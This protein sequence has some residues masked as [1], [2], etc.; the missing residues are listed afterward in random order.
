MKKLF[1]IA[2]CALFAMSS[3]AQN[4]TDEIQ[5]LQSSYGMDKK[6]LI[7]ETMKF[8]E[9][10]SAKFWP[11]YNNYEQERKKLGQ[12]RI[13]NIMNFARNNEGMTNEK[14][15]ELVNATLDNH[16]AFTKL[17]Q[18]TYKE[19]SGAITPLRAAQFIQLE[20]FL[21]NVIRKEI[22][23]AIPMIGKVDA[24]EKK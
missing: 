8:T 3:Q 14:A 7:V 17:Q 23:S 15:A 9:A 16:I 5:L 19:M 6:Q 11:V 12:A 4:T 24:T 1:L 21:E 2:A 20:V 13:D 10:E 18:K 22:S